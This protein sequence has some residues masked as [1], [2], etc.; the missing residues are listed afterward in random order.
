MAAAFYIGVS[1][2]YFT[3]NETSTGSS[4]MAWSSSVWTQTSQSDFE[5][6]VVSNV[7]TSSSPG[8]VSLAPGNCNLILFWTGN[9]APTGWTIISDGTTEPFY[10]RFIRGAASYG[11]TGGA[12]SHTHTASLSVID[13]PS[14]TSYVQS[15]GTNRASSTHT[16]ALSGTVTTGSASNLPLYRNLKVIRYN[17]G[18]PATIPAGAIAIF[19]GTLPNGWTR[20]SAQDGYF[21]MGSTDATTTGG[22]NTHTHTVSGTL[23]KTTSYQGV[24]TATP[25]ISVAA[26]NHTHTFSGTTASADSR[27]P[28]ITVILAQATSTTP[29]PEGMIGMFDT[30][31]LAGWSVLS[32]PGGPFYG[33]FLVGDAVFGN[34]GGA[35]SHNHDDLT[36]NSSNSTVTGNART[37][38]ANVYVAANGH[39]H[40]LTLT[41]SETAAL[42]P[43]IDV[44]IAKAVFTGTLASQVLDTGVDSSRWD[45]LYWEGSLPSGTS[46]TFEVR[47]S[48][49]P[50][51]KTDT[52]LPW[53]PVGGTSPLLAGLPSGRYK[54]WRATLSTSDIAQTPVLAEVRLYYYGN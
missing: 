14:T 27:P 25:R 51:V 52:T 49:T 18:V 24:A 6:G 53:T 29:I 48:D 45:A 4:A 34:T 10:N 3:D 8:N 30:A 39:N 21:I 31:P 12:T 20:Y 32:N 5:A 17:S 23:A 44:I 42:P 15:G 13:G 16:H 19:D 36:I 11:G 7:N 50:F 40:K 46:I 26:T 35:E 43:Y 47:A 33:R 38:G 22:S 1:G 28:Y 41:F 54:Q 9:T 2:A 37:R